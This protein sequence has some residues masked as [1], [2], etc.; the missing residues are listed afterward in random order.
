MEHQWL[1][2]RLLL[3]ATV[4]ATFLAGTVLS[5]LSAQVLRASRESERDQLELIKYLR[6]SE[7]IFAEYLASQPK[8]DA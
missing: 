4:L 1:M 2:T 8:V 6:N 7:L 5:V 3:G